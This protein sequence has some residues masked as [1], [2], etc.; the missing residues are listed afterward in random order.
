MKFTRKT[1]A[2]FGRLLRPPSWKR[3]G[4]ILGGSQEV[5][6]EVRKYN[7]ERKKGIS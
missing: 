4:S 3:N 1:K 6:K 5:S 7:E 2:R